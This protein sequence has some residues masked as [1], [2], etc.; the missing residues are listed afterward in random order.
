MVV[1]VSFNQ[2]HINNP[3]IDFREEF[4]LIVE[5]FKILTFI[6]ICKKFRSFFSF[7]LDLLNLDR[8]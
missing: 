6:M 8:L 3:F 7:Y 2:L 5:L 4:P 1:F